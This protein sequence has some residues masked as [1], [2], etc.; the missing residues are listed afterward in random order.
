MDV[1][2]AL[3]GELVNIERMMEGMEKRWVKQH[4]GYPFMSIPDIQDALDATGKPLL[5]DL[6]I[7]KCQVLMTLAE[8]PEVRNGNTGQG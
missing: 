6:L 5:H 2:E 3:E 7:T 1:R 8:L 4:E